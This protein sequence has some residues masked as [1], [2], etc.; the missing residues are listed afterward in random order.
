MRRLFAALAVIV[1]VFTPIVSSLAENELAYNGSF[2]ELNEES[3]LP[4]GWFFEA[5]Y[6]TDEDRLVETIAKEE[7]NLV[8]IANYIENDVRLCQTIAVKPESYYLLSCDIKAVNVEGGAGANISVRDSFAYAAAPYNATEFTRITLAGKTG[9]DQETLTVCI[10]LGG[11][12]ELSTGDAYFSN[13]SLLKLTAAPAGEIADF[14][15]VVAQGNVGDET[16][17]KGKVPLVGPMIL[18]AALFGIFFALLYKRYFVRRPLNTNEDDKN[19]APL[20]AILMLCALLFRTLLSF[21]FFGHPTDI[22]CFMSWSNSMVEYGPSGFYELAGFADYPPGYMY[23]LWLMGLIARLFNLSYG[24]AGFALLVKLPSIVADLA[25]AYIVYK[26]AKKRFTLKTSLLLAALVAFN[27]TMAFVS[28]AWGQIDQLLALGLLAVIWLFLEKKIVL[29]GLVYGLVILLKPQALMAG[30]LIAV[31][32]FAYLKDFGFKNIVKVITAVLGAL[33]VIVLFALPFT[34][35]QEP[36]WL[37]DKYF[38]T[39]TSYP[40]ASVEAFNLFALFGGNWKSVESIFLFF[41]YGT[42]GTIFILVSVVFASVLYLK[43]RKREPHAL[44]LSAAFLIAALFTLGQYMHERYLFPTLLLLLVAFTQYKDKR[45]IGAYGFLSVS[46]L[47]NV[48]AAFVIVDHQ[49]ARGTEY[50]ALTLAGSAL[51]VAGFIYLTIVCAKIC[52][53]GDIIEAQTG[54]P[55]IKELSLQKPLKKQRFK[56]IDHLLCWGLTA[57]YAVI[58]LLNLGTMQAPETVWKGQKNDTV[59]LSLQSETALS[60]IRVFGGLYDGTVSI[61]ASDGTTLTYQEDNGDMFRWKSIGG[62]DFLT[63]SL[64]LTVTSGK[65]W[66]NEIA[67]FDEEGNFVPLLASLDGETLIDEPDQVPIKDSYLNG[68]YFDEL[69]HA[70]TAY[71]HLHGIKPYENSH[72]PLGKVFIMLGIALF[73]MNAFGWRIVGTVFGIFMVPIFYLFAKQLFKKAEYAFLAAGLFTFDFMHFVQTRIATIDVYGVFFILLMFYFMYRYYTMSFHLEPLKKTLWPLA[74]SGIFFGLGAASKW[75]CIYA[76]AGLAVI[77]FTSLTQRFLEYR[78][79]K[80]SDDPA[81]REA[82][83]DFWSKTLKTLLWCLLFF[84]VVPVIIYL[85]SYLPY[86][87]SSEPYDL[88]GVWDVQKFMFSYHSNLEATHPYESPWWQWPLDIRPIWYYVGY[89]VAE[90]NISTISSFGN[91]AVWI[92]CLFGTLALAMKLLSG[93]VKYEKGMFVLFVGVCAN[94]LPWVL[95]TRCTF[96]YHYFAT[97]PFIILLT[98]Y[99]VKDMDE[100]KPHLRYV[101]WAW[102][103]VVVLLFALFYPALSGVEVP[104]GYISMLEW[105]PSWTFLGY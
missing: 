27:P 51:N 99:L 71:E 44:T 100:F 41:S 20:I 81:L 62:E 39:A 104:K 31:A 10:R 72:P 79:F 87:L 37:L 54:E 11:Y 76:G 86:Y 15:P 98:V 92:I 53:K 23:I 69:Y 60:D 101:K 82:V 13:F 28:G 4:E 84:I 17:D 91:P 40:Y 35:N 1:L 43:G 48:L 61:A 64:T 94:Y 46:M 73:G 70:R 83:A 7:G 2:L 57:V 32:Y 22:A 88:K 30:P 74:L 33:A 66:F 65:V 49:Y 78:R 80:S 89:N 5:W 24:S 75:I 102:L 103:T 16:S 97:V 105:L 56:R 19:A 96:I 34:G 67:V 59:E 42:W 6:D 9:S 85:L 14:S 63:D 55:L 68:M 93:K 45:L 29:A 90:G 25:A 77:F 3:A 58:A 52:L 36:F 26:L 18:S 47:L 38:S 50:D 12:S 95:V 8:H 21:V